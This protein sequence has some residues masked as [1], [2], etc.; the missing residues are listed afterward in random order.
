MPIQHTNNNDLA[1]V[2]TPAAS[3]MKNSLTLML[4]SI[5]L[6]IQ[7]QSNGDTAQNTAQLS[8]I[9]YQAHRLNSVLTQVIGL[10]HRAQGSLCVN[11]S[12]TLVSD[13]LEAVL[14]QNE[15]QSETRAIDI[16]LEVDPDLMWYMDEE[17]MS[18]VIDEVLNSAMRYCHGKV[19]ITADINN[20]H[21]V[22]EINDDGPGYP[23]AMLEAAEAP[24][25]G[26]E[27]NSSKIG[28]GLLFTR[29]ITSAH[30]KNQKSG[31]IQ[32]SNHGKLGGSCFRITL[33]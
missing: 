24:L 22:I 31:K 16:S 26:L 2:L 6:M 32:L 3:D 12:E 8:N 20:E 7:Q 30:K 33:P 1:D 11:I 14:C 19:N 9:N 25:E 10:S 4:Q 27:T 21:L 18:C 29:L 15:L 28:I 5:D 13:L 17:L 23:K